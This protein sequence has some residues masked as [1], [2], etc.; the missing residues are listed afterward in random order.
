MMTTTY[1]PVSLNKIDTLD[2]STLGIVEFAMVLWKDKNNLSKVEF[3]NLVRS[4][5]WS[6]S[7]VN[8]YLKIAETFQD[9]DVSRLT[10]IE[11]R[12]LFKI[13]SNKKFTSVI[14]GIKNSIAHVTQQLVEN[15]IEACR[16]PRT[17]KP[18]EATI[19]R[20]EKDGSRSCVIPPIKED[21]QFTGMAIQRGM[22]IEGIS[23][24]SFI[25]EAVALHEALLCGV[26][27]LTD[28]LP[29]HLESILGNKLRYPKD[30]ASV[31]E[32]EPI[33]EDESIEVVEDIE[34]E[35]E[36]ETEEGCVV[37]EE[38]KPSL[39]VT[40][41][42]HEADFITPQDSVSLLPHE[43]IAALMVQCTTSTELE[44]LISQIDEKLESKSWNVLSD[45][46]KERLTNL[47]APITIKVGDKVNWINC[48]PHI[49]GWLPL[50]VQ[51]I[52]DNGLVQLELLNFLV[53]IQE[54][55]FP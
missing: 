21:D 53:P 17:P 9:I 6:R 10:R 24:Q 29:L 40:S 52:E 55:A 23:A 38:T 1:T 20:A 7:V 33:Y 39:I 14:D 51:R 19:W 54:L 16:T 18:E 4:L 43:K 48:Y 50:Q 15:L 12:T 25:R 5:G 8:G 2:E 42:W 3:K 27:A 31:Y 44:T 37:V 41:V 46:E 26:I 49:S 34:I 36:V 11:P 47:K 35:E 45:A 32:D 13:T 30:V 28:E 22:D